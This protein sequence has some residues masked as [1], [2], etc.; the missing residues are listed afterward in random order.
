[1]EERVLGGLEPADVD[2]R[3]HHAVDACPWRGTA[4]CAGRTTCR[5]RRAARARRLPLASTACR[6]S[7]SSVVELVRERLDRP[8]DVVRHE[9]EGLGDLRRELAD[10]ELR[11]EEDRA[12]V[13]ARQQVVHVVGE[14]GQLGDLAL[15]LGVDRVELLV[16]ALQLLVRALQL[17]VGRLQLFVGACSSS[18]LVSS[19]SIAACRFSLVWLSSASSVLSCSRETWSSSISTA[20]ALR[21]RR[22]RRAFDRLERDQHAAARRRCRLATRRSVTL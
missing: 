21:R 13:G 3:E 12:D 19:S 9:V 5:G 1:M 11:V 2:Q 6:S 8:P 20:S 4:G 15:V 17:L 16:D 14:L 7:T 10:R 18:L 22:S